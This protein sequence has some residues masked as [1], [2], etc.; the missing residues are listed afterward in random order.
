MVGDFLGKGHL[1][2]LGQFLAANGYFPALD[3]SSTK[4]RCHS[5]NR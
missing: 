1:R 2:R 4:E 5:T 3:L